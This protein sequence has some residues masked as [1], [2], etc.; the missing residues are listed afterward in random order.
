MFYVYFLNASK[1]YNS[2]CTCYTDFI[3]NKDGNKKAT[4]AQD[5]YHPLLTLSIVSLTAVRI[6]HY[7][8]ICYLLKFGRAMSVKI[9]NQA[10][11]LK[12]KKLT[13]SSEKW[14]MK[15]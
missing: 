3:W 1:S 13:I 2:H 7:W 4:K 5:A 9:M 14:Y 12:V 11:K 8:F 10:M 15:R 6:Y